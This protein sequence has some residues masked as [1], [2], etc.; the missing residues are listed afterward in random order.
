[1]PDPSW[2]TVAPVHAI[3]PGALGWANK[4][5][6]CDSGPGG[7]DPELD[8]PESPRLP[9]PSLSTLLRLD[10]GA[11]RAWVQ[12]LPLHGSQFAVP[13]H[14]Q[15]DYADRDTLLAHLAARLEAEDLAHFTS[16]ALLEQDLHRW[17]EH[18]V[19]SASGAAKLGLLNALA[20]PAN[21]GPSALRAPLM[22]RL[23]GGLHGHTR[24]LDAALQMLLPDPNVP[25]PAP[26]LLRA[27]VSALWPTRTPAHTPSDP[28][29]LRQLLQ[30]CA[31]ATHAPAKAA[32]WALAIQAAANSAALPALAPALTQLLTS[33]TCAI[34]Q[35]LAQ[36]H[37]DG[38]ALARYLHTLR[39]LQRTP[40]ICVIHRQLR[41]GFDGTE[42]ALA[43]LQYRNRSGAYPHAMALGYCLGAWAMVGGEAPVEAPEESPAKSPGP[44]P[45]PMSGAKSGPMPGPMPGALAAPPAQPPHAA[46]GDLWLA[47]AAFA[48]WGP[49]Q[50]EPMGQPLAEPPWQL[51][52]PEGACRDARQRVLQAHALGLQPLLAA[53]AA[54]QGGTAPPITRSHAL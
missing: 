26:T 7:S 11:L 46:H 19:R 6:P 43:Y 29:P 22:G 48:A 53:P 25:T 28:G 47:G 50:S 24:A 30:A 8:E 3:G 10:G 15:L 38:Q 33:Q 23:L 27:T 44:M 20:S 42:P 37:P 4:G 51:R 39:S 34:V 5:W 18:L 2:A 14:Q 16:A 54:T 35:A 1:M 36:Q 41:Q 13:R 31:S 45:R 49:A 40:E 9:G 17:S 32:L 12:S 52:G 21:P